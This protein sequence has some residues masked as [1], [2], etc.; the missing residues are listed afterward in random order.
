MVIFKG[1]SINVERKEGFP[2]S[3]GIALSKGWGKEKRKKAREDKGAIRETR[4]GCCGFYTVEKS[5]CL[6]WRQREVW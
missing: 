4:M 6:S 2:V 1:T 5:R 3:R